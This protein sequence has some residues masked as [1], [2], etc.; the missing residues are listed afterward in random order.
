M[1]QASVPV[2]RPINCLRCKTGTAF[3]VIAPGGFRILSAL[4]NATKVLSVD[5]ELTAGTNDHA[6]GRHPLGEAYDVSVKN[7]VPSQIIRLKTYLDQ[8]LGKRFTVLIEAPKAPMDPELASLTTI[9]GDATAL[10]VHVQVRKGESYPPVF[11]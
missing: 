7:L 3:K 11:A 9:N 6:S 4:D 8:V 2:Q 10:H 1:G 5:L